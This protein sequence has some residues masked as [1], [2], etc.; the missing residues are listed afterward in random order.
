MM[1]D[2][3]FPVTLLSKDA[4]TSTWSP[5]TINPPEPA[6]SLNV[7]ASARCPGGIRSAN[8]LACTALDSPT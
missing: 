1:T 5:G 6:A 4:M 2:W 3:S 8:V 7:T